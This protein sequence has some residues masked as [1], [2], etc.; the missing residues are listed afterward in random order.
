MIRVTSKH[1]EPPCSCVSIPIYSTFFCLAVK[2]KSQKSK[3]NKI[4]KDNQENKKQSKSSA[5][6]AGHPFIPD[7]IT[8]L[9]QPQ[10]H[11]SRPPLRQLK[12]GPTQ[13]TLAT[14]T[15]VTTGTKEGLA[16]GTRSPT[17][18]LSYAV[19]EDCSESHP[20]SGHPKV[21]QS[22]NAAGSVD[23]ASFRQYHSQSYDAHR[24]RGRKGDVK[25]QQKRRKSVRFIAH[26]HMHVAIEYSGFVSML[27]DMNV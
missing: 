4:S 23:N 12:C 3:A 19:H 7:S 1:P 2:L 5:L 16:E 9:V 24:K 20:S 15:P 14:S 10:Q 21:S 8:P 13:A 11:P 26:T 17:V 27:C 22:W 18:S 6:A 25:Q